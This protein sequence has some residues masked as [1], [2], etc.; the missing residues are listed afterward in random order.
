MKLS[1]SK[2]IPFEV[3]KLMRIK[4]SINTRKSNELITRERHVLLNEVAI[5]RRNASLI[6]L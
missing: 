5:T 4:A 2:E 6:K 1:P 3:N